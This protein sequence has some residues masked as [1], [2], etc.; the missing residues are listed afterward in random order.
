MKRYVHLLWSAVVLL[1]YG[2]VPAMA[3]NLTAIPEQPGPGT[4]LGTSTAYYP[5]AIRLHYPG[6]ANG[7]ILAA[8]TSPDGGRDMGHVFE[9][10]DGGRTFHQIA[11]IDPL[12]RSGL[13]CSVLYELPRQV[14]DLPAGTVLW[15]ATMNWQDRRDRRMSIPVWQSRDQGHSWSPLSTCFAPGNEDGTWEPELSV[16]TAGNLGCYFSDEPALPGGPRG[17]LLS[18]T[19]STDGVHWGP[20]EH[21]VALP[22]PNERPGMTAIRQLSTGQYLMTYERCHSGPVKGDCQVYYRIS[23][24]GHDWGDPAWPGSPITGQDGGYPAHAP[25]TVVLSNGR[26]VLVAQTYNNRN[27]DIE[28]SSGKILLVNDSAGGGTWSPIPAPVQLAHAGN[29]DPCVNYSSALVPANTGIL[30]IATD[31][32]AGICKAYYATGPA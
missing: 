26:I 25:K 1:A 6:S 11:T 19:I 9:S 18:R 7:R 12:A 32:N 20:K 3:A 13:C 29:P 21:I 5:T 23:P 17:Q 10:T 30:E 4:Q 15:A 14:G 28:P 24:D 16:D 31:N 27:G 2:A 8:Y 22:D